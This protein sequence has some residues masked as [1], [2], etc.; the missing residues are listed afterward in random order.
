MV[1]AVGT[2]TIGQ[3]RLSVLG[4]NLQDETDETC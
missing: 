4:Q 3:G 2:P 1:G